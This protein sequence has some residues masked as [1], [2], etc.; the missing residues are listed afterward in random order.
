MYIVYV[1]F[2]FPGLSNMYIYYMCVVDQ[3]YIDMFIPM[4]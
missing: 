3:I 2:L 4:V 1:S